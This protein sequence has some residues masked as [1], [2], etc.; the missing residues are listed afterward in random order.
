MGSMTVYNQ[1]DQPIRVLAAPKEAALAADIIAQFAQL[2]LPGIGNIRTLPEMYAASMLLRLRPRT[3]ALMQAIIDFHG[4][5]A[6]TI[7][8]GESEPA[9]DR[10]WQDF[11]SPLF[12][13]N[14]ELWRGLFRANDFSLYITTPTLSDSALFDCSVADS[15][16]AAPDAIWRQEDESLPPKRSGDSW[17]WNASAVPAP[18]MIAMAAAGAEYHPQNLEIF[19]VGA[20][21]T[22]HHNWV[23]DSGWHSWR[24]DFLGAPKALS[25]AAT[26][27]RSANA[28]PEIFLVGRD[29]A[30]YHNECVSLKGWG[31]WLRW[32]GAPTLKSLTLVPTFGG[33]LH[34]F[35]V[36]RDDLLYHCVREGSRWQSWEQNFRNAGRVRAVAAG[37]SNNGHLQVFIIRDDNRLCHNWLDSGWHDWTPDPFGAPSR[38]ASV[39]VASQRPGALNEQDL[40]VFAVSLDGRLSAGYLRRSGSWV[41]FDHGFG[42]WHTGIRNVFAA[43]CRGESLEICATFDVN[44]IMRRSY[45][46]GSAGTRWGPWIEERPGGRLTA[47]VLAERKRSP[48]AIEVFGVGAD[49][50]VA[51]NYVWGNGRWHDWRGEVTAV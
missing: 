6:R 22:V 9:I 7:L 27:V 37:E 21:G 15:W 18:K 34:L 1:L 39:T 16:I 46:S 28:G 47:M 10:N 29:G 24:A 2:I 13:A 4:K 17:D 35:G 14:P 32:T 36:G 11:S 5:H 23:G 26:T 25:V 50:A 19:G 8:P 45:V 3:E 20:D 48:T 43:S 38:V 31:A 12:L 42:E 49:G 40:F 41:P 44:A 51:H 30:L 33:R